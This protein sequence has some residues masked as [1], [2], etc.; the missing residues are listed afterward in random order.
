MASAGHRRSEPRSPGASSGRKK[1]RKVVRKLID[2]HRENAASGVGTAHSV[3]SMRAAGRDLDVL[4]WD[5]SSFMTETVVTVDDVSS[6]SPR[7]WI[8]QNRESPQHPAKKRLQLSLEEPGNTQKSNMKP[9]P[10]QEI[11]KMASQLRAQRATGSTWDLT[12]GT[13]QT[14]NHRAKTLVSSVTGSVADLDLSTLIPLRLGQPADNPGSHPMKRVSFSFRQESLFDGVVPSTATGRSVRESVSRTSS[15]EASPA[16]QPSPGP[17]ENKMPFTEFTPTTPTWKG[18]GRLATIQSEGFTESSDEQL[19][20][21]NTRQS[22]A[23]ERMEEEE[24]ESEVEGANQ[25]RSEKAMRMIDQA[26]ALVKAAAEVVASEGTAR[27]DI[28]TKEIIRLAHDIYKASL[29]MG[30]A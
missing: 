8:D 10:L 6:T 9:T 22:L 19:P 1:L 14:Q 29:G 24:E 28:H 2:E 17:S 30:T 13:P 5:A 15:G 27:E 4:S 12:P 23:L 11:K 26:S 18:R 25:T 20:R 16:M 3:K 7:G 21:V